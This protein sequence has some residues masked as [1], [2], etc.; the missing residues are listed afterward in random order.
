MKFTVLG[1]GKKTP[2]GASKVVLSDGKDDDVV[3]MP[4]GSIEI[5]L[6]IGER[7]TMTRRKL[8]L[9][10][11]RAVMA[12]KLRKTERLVVDFDIFRFPH[13]T[14]GD[15]ELAEIFAVN[16][17]MA[18]YDHA[19]FLSD[20]KER[21]GEVKEIVF[22]NA[23]TKEVKAGFVRGKIIGEETNACRRLANLPGSDVVPRTLSDEAKK[24][25]KRIGA[26]AKV[27]VLG[28]AEMTKLGM[29]G[30]LG[31]GKGSSEEPRFII[32]E[33][34]G[35]K[36]GEKPVVLVGKGVTFDTGG[37]N[38]KPDAAIS[39]GMNMD[40]SGAAATLHA[41]AAAARI[42]IQRNI[43]VLVP[44][45]ENMPSGSSYRPGDILRS[46]SGKTI[47]VKNTDA[48]GRIILADALTYAKRYDP[49][50]VVDVATLTGAAM[51]ALGERASALFTQDE[52][53]ERRF[54]NWGEESGDFVWPLPL[55]EEYEEEIKGT[56]GD[57]SNTG[58]S[59]WGGTITAAAFLKQFAEGY[60]WIHLD[61]APRM[62]AVEDEFLAKG[63]AGA[64]VRLL[65]KMLREY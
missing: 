59:R 50:V 22:L 28:V 2:I 53:T 6:A 54:R 33:Y 26:K 7:D 31:V 46:M 12:A 34:A 23:D 48:E 61:I 16:A 41:L 18:G 64:P 4:D 14:L 49:K 9:L 38:L 57:V 65:V 51:V 13:L 55:W 47:E 42:G 27:K 37:L 25:A 10:P 56:F 32:V 45:V 24:I 17:E 21:F 39:D 30:V 3:R 62:T 8:M 19:E 1:K 43:V 20:A 29:G 58:R 36:K 40:M 63:A 35:G 44:A 11:R 15:G 5:K 52:E 60:P